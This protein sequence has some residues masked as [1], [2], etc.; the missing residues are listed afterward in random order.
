MSVTGNCLGERIALIA[1]DGSI[2]AS[3]AAWSQNN[4]HACTLPGG[5]GQPGTGANDLA[6]CLN[7]VGEEDAAAVRLGIASV[8][9]GQCLHYQHEFAGQAGALPRWFSISVTPLMQ[10]AGGAAI[11]HQDITERREHEAALRLSAIAL[12][13]RDGIMITDDQGRI[14]KVNRAF[15]KITGYTEEEAQGRSPKLLSSGRHD[16]AFYLAMW[17]IIDRIGTWEG[18]VW[19]RRKNGEVYPERLT[20]AS[21]RDAAGTVTH[22]VG[23][24]SDITN[25]K[26]ASEAIRNLAFYDPLTQLPNRR[27]LLDRLQQ[28]VA[29]IARNGKLGALMF[30]DLDHFKE[31]NDTLGH[32]VG[33]I[34]LQQVARRLRACVRDVDTVARLGG[35]EFVVLIENLEGQSS[36]ARAHTEVVARKILESLASPF[37]LGGH[38]GSITGSI[39]ALLFDDLSKSV[40]QLIEH[41]DQAMYEAK[42]AGRNTVR[43]FAPATPP[44]STAVPE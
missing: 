22:Y 23:S 34:L 8:L 7:V 42:K 40:D 21:V 33:D 35:D 5:D 38:V 1:G 2:I 37:A 32:A 27:L 43:F 4:T 16:A 14:L 9:S 28:A 26:A 31:L 39:G 15:T 13:S 20:I 3:N 29:S 10:A 11:L 30:I 19:N 41:A 18:E 6:A 44:G 17:E 25:S 12:D 24:L 36:E